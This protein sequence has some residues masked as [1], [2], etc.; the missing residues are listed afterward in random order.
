MTSAAVSPDK[1]SVVDAFHVRG[2]GSPDQ[3]MAYIRMAV[4]RLGESVQYSQNGFWGSFTRY[5]GTTY[6]N[7][8]ALQWVGF[9]RNGDNG[10]D[11]VIVGTYGGANR[12]LLAQ[13]A[14]TIR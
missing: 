13:I 5:N 12:E 4:G 2:A 3:A 14:N 1:M 11:A 6:S 9:F 10:V 8:R 7:G